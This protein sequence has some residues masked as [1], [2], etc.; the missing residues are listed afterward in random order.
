MVRSHSKKQQQCGYHTMQKYQRNLKG[1]K[2]NRKHIP[3]LNFLKHRTIEKIK[4][5]MF[6]PWREI[7]YL[8]AQMKMLTL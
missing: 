3:E 1:H 2:K 7:Y 5:T 8:S 6:N 4:A